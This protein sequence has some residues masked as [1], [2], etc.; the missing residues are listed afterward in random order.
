VN[1]EAL[2]NISRI[3][4]ETRRAAAVSANFGLWTDVVI[5]PQAVDDSVPNYT[6]PADLRLAISADECQLPKECI[7]DVMGALRG[8]ATFEDVES[9][10]EAL[11]DFMVD[12]GFDQLRADHRFVSLIQLAVG[13]NGYKVDK[14]GLKSP[15]TK[16]N[17]LTHRATRKLVEFMD[18]D[19]ESIRTYHGVVNALK[20]MF[21][22]KDNYSWYLTKAEIVLDSISKF[23][24]V[25]KEIGI[26]RARV[27]ETAASAESREEIDGLFSDVMQLRT[28]GVKQAFTGA[29][30]GGSYIFDDSQILLD[31]DPVVAANA[32]SSEGSSYPVAV[33]V[34]TPETNFDE[35]VFEQR[36][37]GK[38]TGIQLNYIAG[39]FPVDFILMLAS[40]GELYIDNYCSIPVRD[41]FEDQDAGGA[42]EVLR[43]ELVA[44]FCDLVMPAEIVS[45]R[46]GQPSFLVGEL[47]QPVDEIIY[48]LLLPRR[49]YIKGVA[50]EDMDRADHNDN[51]PTRIIREHGVVYHTRRLLPGQQASP[52]ARELARRH[53]MILPADRTFVRSHKRGSGPKVVGHS[54]VGSVS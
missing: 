35:I 46:D 42:Y 34:A 28:Y 24:A 29:R 40:D 7:P 19:E 43:A 1:N 44:D 10:A 21:E 5:I 39:N 52:Q 27:P 51:D 18:I 6:A 32:V 9:A 16:Q 4:I 53:S 48:D 45:G 38:E 41:M 15:A 14:F 20:G 36:T 33:I 54:F 49:N 50:A 22:V 3:P 11:A 23:R 30:R 2:E 8:S 13:V 37:Y 47:N 26:A 31:K 12:D 25:S 17:E